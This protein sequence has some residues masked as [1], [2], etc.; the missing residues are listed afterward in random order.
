VREVSTVIWLIVA[1][2]F[3]SFVAGG[4]LMALLAAAKDTPTQY[5]VGYL[6]GRRDEREQVRR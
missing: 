5:V 2:C 4:F 1:L 6:K 3:L